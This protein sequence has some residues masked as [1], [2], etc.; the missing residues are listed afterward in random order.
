[1]TTWKWKLAHQKYHK[2]DQKENE[3]LAENNWNRHLVYKWFL[4]INKKKLTINITMAKVY[5]NTIVPTVVIEW[6]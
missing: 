4:D 6:F 3:K 2:Q 1:M 5:E